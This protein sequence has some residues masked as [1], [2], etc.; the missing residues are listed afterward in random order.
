MFPADEPDTWRVWQLSVRALAMSAV[1]AAG[2]LLML[3]AV[4]NNFGACPLEVYPIDPSAP[5]YTQCPNLNFLGLPRLLSS[6]SRAVMFLQVALPLQV[7]VFIARTNGLFF[8]R[9]PGFVLL[10]AILLE[11]MVT[12]LLA[13]FWPGQPV[14][15]VPNPSYDPACTAPGMCMM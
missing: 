8:T 6:Q 14:T 1:C 7:T 9:R 13:I 15:L 3:T 11:M 10:A 12:T 4:Q 5:G 2:A